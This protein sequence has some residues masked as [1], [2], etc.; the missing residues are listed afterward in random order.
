VLNERHL[1]RILLSYIDYY[2][3]WL[4]HLL[5]GMDSLEA[6]AVQPPSLEKIVDLTDVGG[7]HHRYERLAA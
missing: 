5:L 4:A 1:K 3:G 2:H 6:R 7:L